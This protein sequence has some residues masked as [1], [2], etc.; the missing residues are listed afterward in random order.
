MPQVHCQDD[1]KQRRLIVDKDFIPETLTWCRQHYVPPVKEHVHCPDFGK[2]DGMNGSCWWCMEMTPYQWHMCQDETWVIGLLS[3]VA[4][5][6]HKDRA[7]AIAF[8]EQHKQ[9]HPQGNERRA[10][11]SSTEHGTWENYSAT[12]MVC[13]ICKR[14]VPYHRYTYCPHCGSKMDKEI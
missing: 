7:D 5:I 10:L 8:I 3:P 4:R 1:D 6:K 12:M 14:H 13:S 9:E 11:L 2:S